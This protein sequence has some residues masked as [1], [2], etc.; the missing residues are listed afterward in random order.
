MFKL[1]QRR[2]RARPA[3]NELSGR[4]DAIV[5]GAGVVGVTT[6]YALARRGLKVAIVDRA[7]GPARG[8]SYAN[9]AQLSYAYTD[10]LGSPAMLK[11]LPMLVLGGDPSFRIQATIDPAFFQWGLR[12]LRNCTGERF[13]RNTR[14]GLALALESRLAMHAL[15][16]RHP[17]DFG[18][19]APGK[20]HLFYDHSA[21]RAAGE[22]MELKRRHG[23]VQA[24]L[25]AEEAIAIEPALATATGIAGVI[26][27]PED[28]VGDP[29]RFASGLLDILIRDYGVEARFGC[30]VDRL[31]ID[32][33]TARISDAT[34][35]TI[36]GKKLAVCLG[37][38]A[39]RWLRKAGI[40]VPVWPMKGYSFTARCGDAA[41][42]VSIT[43]TARKVVFCPL[44]GRM[45]VAG[46]AELG[47]WDPSLH[48][49]PLRALIRMA[50]TSL[51]QAAAYDALES[52][53]AGLRPMSPSS[54][55]IIS[56][57]RPELLLNIGHG[58]LGWTFAMGTAER[59]ASLIHHQD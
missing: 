44:A 20:M 38:A 1:H 5:L 58:M 19:A 30:H 33:G 50:R 40:R 28:E 8:T 12:F 4:F 17:F 15:T 53:W 24:A 45:R 54:L 34:G 51:P 43:D 29:F 55:P 56:R 18:H 48:H 16:E 41:P 14:A 22:V 47:V 23:A 2:G 27:S 57:P 52:E 35:A 3:E 32:R 11:K 59:A 13:S 7:E 42:R 31:E 36:I 10:A 46:L 9:G 25:T 6:A 26:Y 37:I 21:F 39:P 49:Q